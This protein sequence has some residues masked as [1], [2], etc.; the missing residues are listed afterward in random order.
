MSRLKRLFVLGVLIGASHPIFA[1]PTVVC[2][3]PVV[4]FLEIENSIPKGLEVDLIEGFAKAEG[5]QTE[6]RLIEEFPQVLNSVIEAKCDIAAAAITITAERERNLDF[7]ISYFPARSAV[8][9]QYNRQRGILG[10]EGLAGTKIAVIP[11]TIH[12]DMARE[13][14][15]IELV[16]VEDDYAMWQAVAEGKAEALICDS[17]QTLRFFEEF[18][19]LHTTGMLSDR[20][21]YGL[22]FPKGSKL[23]DRFNK[24]LMKLKES[25]AYRALLGKHFGEDLA[26][27]LLD[28]T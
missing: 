23:R 1:D 24:Y 9:E 18:P 6:T 19:L 3:R 10:W 20:E 5:L 12:D 26:S 14:N 25:G 2:L 21:D 8:V 7:S 15:D 11:G 28:P 16:Y 27:S 22:A 4:G 17:W 13:Q